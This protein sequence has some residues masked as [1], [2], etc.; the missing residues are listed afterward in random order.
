MEE[1]KWNELDYLIRRTLSWCELPRVAVTP[2]PGKERRTFLQNRQSAI[3]FRKQ[4]PKRLTPKEAGR[5][6]ISVKRHISLCGSNGFWTLLR[7]AGQYGPRPLCS[8]LRVSINASATDAGDSWRSMEMGMA[9]RWPA[10]QSLPRPSLELTHAQLGVVGSE[11]P[12][13]VK[14]KRGLSHT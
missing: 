3:W 7:D 12:F 6:Y 1:R 2:S 14:E 5:S 4:K 9:T 13:Q 10:C 8:C 11:R